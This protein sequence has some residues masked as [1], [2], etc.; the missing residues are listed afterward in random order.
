M[1]RLIEMVDLFGEIGVVMLVV[2]GVVVVCIIIGWKL[3][4]LFL[5]MLIMWC[6]CRLSDLV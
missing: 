3:L 4:L 5:E 2:I 6:M 1:F